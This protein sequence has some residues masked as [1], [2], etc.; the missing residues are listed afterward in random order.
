MSTT[1]GASLTLTNA[2]AT[3][4]VTGT[5]GLTKTGNGTLTISGTTA[6]QGPTN[7]NGG[8][9]EEQ[10]LGFFSSTSAVNFGGGTLALDTTGG[11]VSQNLTI[12]GSGYSNQ[13]AIENLGNS[14]TLSG[15]ITLGDAP[16]STR[17]SAR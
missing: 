4:P 7:V 1:G 6:Y 17:P 11:T 5:G 9:L 14:L 15:N 12:A 2:T 10:S 8:V 3:E 16:P 13:V